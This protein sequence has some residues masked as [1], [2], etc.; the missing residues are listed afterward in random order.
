MKKV[1]YSFLS[2]PVTALMFFLSV[3][4][5]GCYSFFNI[6]VELSPETEFPSLSV[7]VSWPGA[8]PE[9]VEA[10]ITS[11]MEAEFSSIKNLVNIRSASSEGNCT[12]DMDFRSDTDMDFVRIQI[13]EKIYSIKEIL[14]N[15]VSA[16]SLVP[17]IPESFRDLQGFMTLTISGNGSDSEIRNF[18][19]KN[20]LNKI[21]SVEGVAKAEISGG[22]DR[23]I[24][25]LMDYDKLKLYGITQEEI[26]STIRIASGYL[27]DAAITSGSRRILITFPEYI[28]APQD[29]ANL[30][31]RN[32]SGGVIRISDIC[33]V[34]DT[35]QKQTNFVRINGKETV[36][37]DITKK[38]GANSLVT[39]ELV[40]EKTID[41]EK[42]L[43][44][45]FNVRIQQDKSDKMREE[46]RSLSLNAMFGLFIILIIL[47]LIFHRLRYSLIIF[48]SIL[49]SSA[50]T[51]LLFY[52]SGTD[53]NIV[54]V[55][56]LAV[57][58]GMMVDNSIVVTD[59]L[60]S[61]LISENKK[62]VSV[63]LKE[64]FYPVFLST[65]TT[66]AIFIPVI[67]L[68]G[69]VRL[70][71]VQFAL[72][73]S[74][75][76]VSSLIASFT[77]M[78]YFYIKFCRKILSENTQINEQQNECNSD[79]I[80]IEGKSHNKKQNRIFELYA[81]IQKIVFQ[82]KKFAIIFLVWMIGLPV[83][84]I[85]ERIED[86][87]FGEYYNTIF[88]SDIWLDSREYINYAFGG[89]LNLLANH[90][91]Y[92]DP[93]EFG[94]DSQLFIMLT[95]PNGNDISQI[96]NV[97]LNFENE[98]LKYRKYF[99]KVRVDIY[100]EETAYLSVDFSKKQ[101]SSNAPLAIKQYLI[102]LAAMTGGIETAIMGFGEGFFNGMGGGGIRN[103]IKI[104]GY[105]YN[106]MKKLAGR[107]SD[108]LSKSKRIR[109]INTES[110]GLIDYGRQGF[111]I[112]GKVNKKK[113]SE[114][115]A[116]VSELIQLIAG[117]INSGMNRVNIKA[118][119][120]ERFLQLSFR[121][122]ENIQLEELNNTIFKTPAG[123]ELKIKDLVDFRIE[124]VP[125]S[126][127]R[128]N[129]QYIKAVSYEF[130]GAQIIAD[131]FTD[132][133]LNKFS[134]PEGY[135]IEKEYYNFFMNNDERFEIEIVILFAVVL[136]FMICAGLFES[137]KKP[138]LV[139]SALPFSI[140]GIAI[141]FWYFDLQFNRGS[142]AGILLLIGIAVNNSILM[143]DYISKKSLSVKPEDI[144]AAAY[145]RIRPVMAT[146]LTTIGGLLPIMIY[147]SDKFWQG[148]AFAVSGGLM[149]SAV[150][151]ILYMPL[152]Y[153]YAQ[154]KSKEKSIK[155]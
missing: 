90:I 150:M 93:W 115:G 8:P 1:F 91:T 2:R 124:K 77:F 3:L 4:L 15:D 123:V 19:K 86:E 117:R 50:L 135:K 37:I 147:S 142:Y 144:V 49:F 14:P 104:T 45:G 71:L 100:N 17:Y 134:P 5:L 133:V 35:Y 56:A 10:R 113:L 83:W 74:Y 101:A 81:G 143:V 78:P 85:P 138:I 41:L 54:S 151:I 6:P 47:I 99:D 121:S 36:T 145:M 16:I 131:R 32:S 129:K 153:Y 38:N 23:I 148:I 58:F 39:S 33:E 12:I 137:L 28:K 70:Y 130:Q 105:N 126:I 109:N 60:Q 57:G 75:A 112:F 51:F 128:E 63:L 118:G 13:N 65:F 108:E 40:R 62:R 89:C 98:I 68:S 24:N 92:G 95:V 52:F 48:S 42:T 155:P 18:V 46:I 67:F 55:A 97:T 87:T 146:T 11:I 154:R 69:E 119:R 139:I 9:A 26:L 84:M 102:S 27:S 120:E 103:S 64:I 29:I 72:A 82:Y 116:D 80:I 43:L 31:V 73:I 122:A 30:I 94:R 20:I 114:Y 61:H 111:E 79:F 110:A 34:Q 127:K 132:A 96:K 21:R 106:E 44:K 7:Q 149:F 152:F 59:Y 136:M 125:A 76:V 25:I 66:I 22:S 107:L 88:Q 141:V 53:I 140:M